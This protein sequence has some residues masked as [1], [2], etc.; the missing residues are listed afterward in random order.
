MEETK[1]ENKVNIA[2]PEQLIN[3]VMGVIAKFISH[4]ITMQE[5]FSIQNELISAF[6]IN[7]KPTEEENGK[8]S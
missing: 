6:N 1:Q 2:T 5:G 7:Q 8:T 3:F 4:K